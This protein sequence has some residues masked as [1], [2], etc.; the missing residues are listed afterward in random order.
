M[1]SFSWENGNVQRAIMECS[2]H[3]QLEGLELKGDPE[4]SSTFTRQ[5]SNLEGASILVLAL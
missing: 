2:Q 3:V 4:L 5:G 1:K